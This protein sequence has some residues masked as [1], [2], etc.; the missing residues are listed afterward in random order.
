MWIFEK[1]ME[2]PVKIKN[3]NPALARCGSQTGKTTYII[4]TRITFRLP[5]RGKPVGSARP[6]PV[7][8]KKRELKLTNTIELKCHVQILIHYWKPVRTSVT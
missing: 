1:K 4:Y 6:L 2:F 7:G 3:T 5:R 8:L